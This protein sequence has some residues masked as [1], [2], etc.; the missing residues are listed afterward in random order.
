MRNTVMIAAL[1]SL[2]ACGGGGERTPANDTV[3]VPE[4]G[5][6]T[7]PAPPATPA[8][9]PS[10]ASSAAD[11]GTGIPA[12]LQ[13][14]WGLVPADCTSTKGDNKGLL[15]ISG[16]TLRFYESVGTLGNVVSREP[17]RIVADFAMTGEGQQ[18]TRRMVLDM[19]ESGKTLIRRELGDD[20]MPNPLRY[21]RCA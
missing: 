21:Q 14:R 12:A 16:D 13:G 11:S 17:T 18:W 2:A 6:V 20:A 4:N 10:T 19:H 3:A 7:L 5:A 15:T 8:D 1:L 9:T